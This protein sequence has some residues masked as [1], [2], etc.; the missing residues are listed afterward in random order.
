[1]IRTWL[2]DTN[3]PYPSGDPDGG[4]VCLGSVRDSEC[5]E[6]MSSPAESAY[7]GLH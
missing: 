2:V 3:A 5:T 6:H 1:M 7:F 4:N